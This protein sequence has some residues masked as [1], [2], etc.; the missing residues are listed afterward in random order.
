LSSIYGDGTGLGLG[1]VIGPGDGTGL[2]LG[3]VIGPGDCGRYGGTGVGEY[4]GGGNGTL[5]PL[6]IESFLIIHAK[7]TYAASGVKY[8]K[9][10]LNKNYTFYTLSSSFNR[11]YG[12]NGFY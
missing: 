12:S 3:V 5:P 8:S 10:Y 1:V 2:G 6:Y 9:S 11:T 7:N 4:G